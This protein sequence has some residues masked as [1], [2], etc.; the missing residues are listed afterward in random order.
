[1]SRAFCLHFQ[2]RL[3]VDDMESIVR[4]RELSMSPDMP[5]DILGMATPKRDVTGA[6]TAYFKGSI[7]PSKLILEMRRILSQTPSSS[8][9]IGNCP[10]KMGQLAAKLAPKPSFH[11][12]Q[13]SQFD[14][15]LIGPV[16]CLWSPYYHISYY[17]Y[18]IYNYII[19]YMY[20]YVSGCCWNLALSPSSSA[21]P[22]TPDQGYEEAKPNLR[23]AWHRMK[24]EIG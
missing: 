9:A 22:G 13:E 3:P 24:V 2:V 1:M 5:W 7:I 11:P 20:I 17:I 15:R 14:L 21:Q 18:Y 23:F 16:N 10:T 8:R 19:I 6:T 4:T 12:L